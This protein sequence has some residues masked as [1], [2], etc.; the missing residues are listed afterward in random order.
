MKI[1]LITTAVAAVLSSWAPMG[2]ARESVALPYTFGVAPGDSV[3]QATGIDTTGSG[4]LTINNNLNINSLNDIGGGITSSDSEV[5]SILF[6][7][8]STISGFTGTSL[9]RFLDITAGANNTTVNFNG[10]VFT[11]QFHHAG[12]G[13]V[14][15]NGNVN[16]SIV[17]SSY[18]FGGDG[19]LNIGTNKIFNSALT[20]TAGDNTGTLSFN[21]G[22]SM[23]GAIGA[24][25]AA[26][27]QI[28]L[29]G[30][31]VNI[32][33]AI[34]VKGFNLASN[35]LSMT[36]AL[37]TSFGGTIATTFASNT[38]FGNIVVTGASNINAAGLTVVPTVTGA[39]TNGTTYRI[40]S[41]GSGTDNAT[42]LVI[43]NNPRYTFSGLPTSLGNIDII[44]TAITP[45]STLVISP[46]A[47]V[48]AP[49]LDVNAPVNTDLRVVQDAIATLPTAGAINNALT[50]L[51]P[52]NTNLAAPWVAVQATQLITDTWMARL[53]EIRNM[54]CDTACDT[55]NKQSSSIQ[56]NECKSPEKHS[57]WWIK[58]VG[59]VGSQDDAS[60]LNG[61]QTKAVGVMLGY[62]VAVS[63]NTRVGLGGGYVNSHIDGNH[64]DNK[65]KVDSYHLTTY[66]KFAPEAFFIQGAVT[67]GVDQYNGSRHIEFTGV[68]RLARSDV[69]GQQY[70]AS[71][72]AGKH[73]GFNETS[74]TP[75]LGLQASYLHVAS[76]K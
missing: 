60:N 39:L 36:G 5:A 69:N 10:D 38:N 62:D 30:G 75:L 63:E 35:T 8:N 28:N 1:R 14:N 31:D 44:L 41:A 18:I 51:A 20:T 23:I 12:S 2:S 32:I 53:D 24:E 46:E 59:K 40:L 55:S 19:V 73:F 47:I 72:S 61:Y 4:L 65:T 50:Q 45:L 48:V 70:T 68:N 7:G 56:K 15:F 54:C 43:N 66:F 27:K 25:S 52:A 17:A 74:I 29:I 76:Y 67:A 9:I 26:L 21:G 16:Q 71:I 13:T 3:G 22:N 64:S 49:I 57:N 11:T 34:F 33:G 58:G 42:I 37:T 6:I